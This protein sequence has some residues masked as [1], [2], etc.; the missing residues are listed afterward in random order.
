MIRF[1]FCRNRVFCWDSSECSCT[2]DR[3]SKRKIC[4]TMDRY[5]TT[6]ESLYVRKKTYFESKSHKGGIG[7]YALQGV[8]QGSVDRGATEQGVNYSKKS[9]TL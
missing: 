3:K 4:F 6:Q 2:L 7:R 9:R 8:T 5:V 1:Y